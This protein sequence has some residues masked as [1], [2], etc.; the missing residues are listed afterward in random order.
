MEDDL[1]DD[2]ASG[3]STNQ[4]P[5]SNSNIGSATQSASLVSITENAS[6][7]HI[8]EENKLPENK[9]EAKNLESPNDEEVSNSLLSFFGISDSAS[10]LHSE[11]NIFAESLQDNEIASF[12]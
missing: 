8:L 2:N 1:Q 9:D 11:V 6:A 4:D 7:Q 3:L 5:S 10:T 12:F